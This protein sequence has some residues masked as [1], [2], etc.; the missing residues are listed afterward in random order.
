LLSA[1]P[2]HHSRTQSIVLQP[3]HSI[4]HHLSYMMSF[5]QVITF[6]VATLDMPAQASPNAALVGTPPKPPKSPASAPNISPTK[7]PPSADAGAP[8]TDAVTIRKSH[9]VHRFLLDEIGFAFKA[10]MVAL[11]H[12][13]ASTALASDHSSDAAGRARSLLNER[14]RSELLRLANTIV[15]TRRRASRKKP[16]IITGT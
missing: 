14:E 11:R 6:P 16:G 2:V 10:D 8:A 7:P 13:L 4:E 12:A 3:T 15:S 9:L 5:M 1:T